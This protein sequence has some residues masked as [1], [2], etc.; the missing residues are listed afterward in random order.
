MGD[1]SGTADPPALSAHGDESALTDHKAEL[2]TAAAFGG[3]ALSAAGLP[4][5]SKVGCVP[6]EA[7]EESGQ[8]GQL[9]SA[10]A[11]QPEASAPDQATRAPV[12]G[13]PAAD[14]DQDASSAPAAKGANVAVSPALG[15]GHSEQQTVHAQ[16]QEPLVS[17]NT[18]SITSSSAHNSPSYK[19]SLLKR[20]PRALHGFLSPSYI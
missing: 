12:E 8:A 1:P 7:A 14:A 6:E 15:V 16:T 20:C 13:T 11:R 4:V 2:A 18:G 10:Q 3:T 9:S 5:D 17:L 19:M